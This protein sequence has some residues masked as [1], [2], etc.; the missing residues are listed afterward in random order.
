MYK[1]IIDANVWIKYARS[2]DIAPLLKRIIAYN[3]L[4]VVNNYLLSEI[5]NALLE[6]KWMNEKKAGLIIEFIKKIS[7]LVSEKAV[8]GIVPDPKDNYLFD[9]AVQN[10]CYFMIM[11]D[12]ILLE[13]TLRPIPVHTSRWFLKTFP[14]GLN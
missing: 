4:P 12:S 8:Y 5:F 6:N 7:L 2:K 14:V 10:R 9:L 11:D 1:I 13:F 3:F